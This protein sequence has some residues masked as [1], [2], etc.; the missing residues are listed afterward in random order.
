MLTRKVRVQIA[1]FLAVALVGVSYAGARYAGLDRLFGPRGYVV[2]VQL[3]S[4]GGIFPNAEVTYRGVQVGRVGELELTR[5]GVE[6]PL[7]IE[8]SA[9]RIPTDVRAVVAN[10]S[11]V[12]EQYVD[13]RPRSSDGPYLHDGSVVREQDTTTPLPVEDLLHNV[14]SLV[15]SVPED[16]LRTVVDELGTAFEGNGDELQRVLDT[17]DEFTAE[18][19]A[20]LPQTKKLLA[21]T[22]TVLGTQNDQASAVR[23]FSED[24]RLVSEQLEKSD[25]DIRAILNRGTPAAEEVSGVLRRTGPKLSSLMANGIPTARALEDNAAGLEQMFVTYPAVSAGG[26]TVAPGDGSAHFGLVLNAFDP[27][28]CVYEG[29]ERRAGNELTPVP[30]NSDARC[31]VPEDSPTAVRGGRNAPD[32]RGD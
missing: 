19:E 16:S 30:L 31:E 1:A 29:T 9:P 28:P 27:M 24:L 14:D 6:V 13:L 32:G 10:R 8:P 20:H 21:D 23:S 5:D 11:V 22:T 26:F 17:A 2:T 15:E 7:D 25:G 18:A 4:S 12:G 3:A